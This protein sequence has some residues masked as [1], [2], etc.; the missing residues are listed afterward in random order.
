MKADRVYLLHIRDAIDAIASYTVAG[1]DDFMAD[2]KTQDAVLRNLEIVGE[3]TKR[4]SRES[5]SSQ[6]DVAW[7]QIAGMRDRLIHAYFGVDL[8]L[9]WEVVEHRLPDLRERVVAM[10]EGLDRLP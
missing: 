1:K 10:I 6:A 7:Q 4:L 2:R 9:V 3:A 8:R 5:R